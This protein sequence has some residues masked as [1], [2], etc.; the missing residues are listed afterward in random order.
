MNQMESFNKL[1]SFLDYHINQ[2]N[3]GCVT[4]LPIRCG[5]GK[6]TYIRHRISDT[7]RNGGNGLIVITDAI[8]RMDEY[9]NG[10]DVLSQFLQRNRNKVA[11]LTNQTVS[12][13][14][15][16]QW[17]KPILIMTTQRYFNLTRTEIMDFIRYSGGKRDKIIFDEKPYLIEQ[18]QIDIGTFNDVDTAL[19]SAIDDTVDPTEK[20]WIINQWENL[21][22]QIETV[23]SNYESMNENQMEIWHC[24]HNDTMTVNDERFFTFVNKYRMKLNQFDI[25]VYANILAIR[26][27]IYEGATFT[28]KKLSSGE[29]RKYFSVS[30]DNSDKLLNL[31][32]D[33]FVLDGTADI[34]PEY[35]VHYVNMIDCREFLIP[36]SNLTIN[37]VN[38]PTSKNQLCRPGSYS[39]GIIQCIKDYLITEPEDTNVIFTYKQIENQ[40]KND[41]PY[42]EHFG[43]IKGGNQYRNDTSIAQVG[44]NRYPDITYKQIAY[45]TKLLEHNFGNHSVT[46]WIGHN[47]V[48]N[49]MNLSLLADIEQNLFRSKIRNVDCTDHITYTIFLNTT[50]YSNLIELMI[51]RYEKE[52]GATINVIQSPAGY[53]VL[54]SKV[55][56][57]DAKTNVQIVMEWLGSQPK[58]REF[59]PVDLRSECGLTKEQYKNVKKSKAISELLLKMSTDTLGLYVVR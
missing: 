16:T 24:N 48:E 44:L 18:R 19:H 23:I 2:S 30:I 4:V 41:F 43:N 34:N 20:T 57:T 21:R 49:V 55:R 35:N 46:R 53:Q 9:L 47:A 1:K 27:L 6:S 37:L 25:T 36:L 33:V 58:G 29:Y 17:Q 32:A 51:D 38:I 8:D 42:V 15:K 52:L 26:Q 3:T 31:G 22:N 39:Q 10:E 12:D 45:L 54:K 5:L 40:F 50:A 28:S 14:L 11:L 7:L 13:E 56:N 59:S